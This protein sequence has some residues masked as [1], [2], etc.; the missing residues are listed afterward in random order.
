MAQPWCAQTAVPPDKRARWES[1]QCDLLASNSHTRN[2][3]IL[4]FGI[5]GMTALGAAG[6]RDF[7]SELCSI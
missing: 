1:G 2:T 6:H 5:E 4:S 3:N 7:E